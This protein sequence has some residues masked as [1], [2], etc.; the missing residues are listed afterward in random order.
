MPNGPFATGNPTGVPNSVPK[1]SHTHT[2]TRVEGP[3][4]VTTKNNVVPNGPV[5]AKVIV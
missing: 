3:T 1:I 5:T 4:K 2:H